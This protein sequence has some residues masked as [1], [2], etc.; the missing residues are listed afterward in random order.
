MKLAFIGRN[1]LSCLVI[2]VVDCMMFLMPTSLM[3]FGH[4]RTKDSDPNAVVHKLLRLGEL[5]NCFSSCSV[6]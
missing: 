6:T 5:V 3:I 1:V 4:T 2:E